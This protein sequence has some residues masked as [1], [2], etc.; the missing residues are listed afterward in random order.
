MDFAEN[1]EGEV[2]KIDS[3]LYVLSDLFV[4]KQDAAGRSRLLVQLVRWQRKI[5]RMTLKSMTR[6]LAGVGFG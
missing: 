3:N 4:S 1:L 5:C 2:T 6:V